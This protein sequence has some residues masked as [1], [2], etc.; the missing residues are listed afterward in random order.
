MYGTTTDAWALVQAAELVRDGDALLLAGLAL[1]QDVRPDIAELDEVG[2]SAEE[3][4]ELSTIGEALAE[5][6]SRIQSLTAQLPMGSVRLTHAEVADGSAED[7][8]RGIIDP[9]RV[10]LA[11]RVLPVGAGWHMLAQALK[12]AD[13]HAGWQRLAIEDLLAGFRGA[14]SALV[15]RVLAAAELHP[16]AELADC[17][18][19]DIAR[20]AAALEEH[21]PVE[22]R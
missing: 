5:L 15:D 8:C 22:E 1:L 7:L 3:L 2:L 18:E 19:W 13:T 4:A 11:A 6:G 20:L 12:S 17:D 16:D 9:Q 21:A 10:T 14:T